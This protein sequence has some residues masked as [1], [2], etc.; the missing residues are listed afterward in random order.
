MIN[1][2][3]VHA[4]DDIYLIESAYEKDMNDIGKI[5][6]DFSI[7]EIRK[8]DME[9]LGIY[10]ESGDEFYQEAAADAVRN[11]GDK[12]ISMIET[13]KEFINS[14]IQKIKSRHW[15][16]KDFDAKMAE[17]QKTR[18]EIADKVKAAVSSGDLDFNNFKDISD[19]YKNIDGVLDELD[20]GKVDPKSLK[21][22][23]QGFKKKL[24]ESDKAIKAVAGVVGIAGTVS[25]IY[26]NYK[27]Y[28]KSKIEDTLGESEKIAALA[29]K[30]LAKLEKMNKKLKEQSKNGDIQAASKQGILAEITASINRET[31]LQVTKRQKLHD[32]IMSQLDKGYQLFMKAKNVPKSS[33]SKRD[34]SDIRDDN[35]AEANQRRISR[36]FP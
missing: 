10:T 24:E 1:T 34:I 4:V 11:L 18:P 13:I 22:R 20:K 8:N 30:E 21:G 6:T 35:I 16:N 26:F 23:L 28:K 33:T 31:Q 32:K 9:M 36:H 17:I 5:M 3:F 2:D 12:I 15:K 7:A 25:T 14:T 29:D 19:F 27:K